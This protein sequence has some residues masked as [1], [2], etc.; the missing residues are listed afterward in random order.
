MGCPC[1]WLAGGMV[2]L[3]LWHAHDSCLVSFHCCRNPSVVKS[4]EAKSPTQS[5]VSS[6]YWLTAWLLHCLGLSLGSSHH[7]ALV[8]VFCRTFGSFS[9]NLLRLSLHR[10]WRCHVRALF[11]GNSPLLTWA[12]QM[13]IVQETALKPSMCVWESETRVWQCCAMWQSRFGPSFYSR[14]MPIGGAFSAQ[15][16]QKL[17]SKSR[18]YLKSLQLG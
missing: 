15:P 18:N 12:L 14:F 11:H 4:C 17:K 8:F 1:D 5:H 7:P 13:L 2:T 3:S 16:P 9:C 6:R 10:V